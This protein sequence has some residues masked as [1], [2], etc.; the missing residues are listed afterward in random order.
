MFWLIVS[1]IVVL[2]GS[3]GWWA[4]GRRRKGLDAA[5]V[6]RSR[7]IDEGRSAP[8]GGPGGI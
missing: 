3:G 8:W 4:S 2:L 7:S 6:L 5:D 1:V